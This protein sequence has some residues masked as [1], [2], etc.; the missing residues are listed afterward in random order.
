M[1]LKEQVAIV[2]GSSRGIGKAIA[3]GFAREGARV[4]VAARTETANPRL[5]GTIYQTAEEIRAAGGIALP[6]RCDV[7]MEETI[8]AMVNTVMK[9]FGGIDI[10]VNDCAISPLGGLLDLPIKH[11]DLTWMVNFRGYYLCSRFVIPR[12]IERGGGSLINITNNLAVSRAPT[13]MIAS[14]IAKAAVERLTYALAD[15]VGKY[16]IAVNGLKPRGPVQSE[17]MDF[18]PSHGDKSRWE[19]PDMMVKAAIFL[20]QQRA[21]NGISGTIT[22]DEVLLLSHGQLSC[23]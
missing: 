8:E 17:G 7:T 13:L 18:L 19:P 22:S 6:V 3:K 1:K 10:L 5:P 20:A 23:I 11:F 15:E 16:N 4:V 9:E 12:M 14:A 2:V 21:K